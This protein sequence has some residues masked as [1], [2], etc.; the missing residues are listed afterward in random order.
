M[1]GWVKLGYV[2]GQVN[3]IMSPSLILTQIPTMTI[4][5]TATLTLTV[6]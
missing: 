3:E 1:F 4:T 5:L 6:L 2:S